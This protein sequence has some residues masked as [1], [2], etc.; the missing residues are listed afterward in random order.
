[1]EN[2]IPSPL[3]KPYLCYV[4]VKNDEIITFNKV[5]NGKYSLFLENT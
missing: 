1:M 4:I 3:K 2:K 5:K